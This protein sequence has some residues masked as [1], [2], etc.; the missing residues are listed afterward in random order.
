[1]KNWAWNYCYLTNRKRVTKRRRGILRDNSVTTPPSK[2]DEETEDS[3]E[4]AKN[5]QQQN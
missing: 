2:F 5:P 1:M 4:K 3:L